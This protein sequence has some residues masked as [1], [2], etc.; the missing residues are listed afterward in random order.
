MFDGCLF[1]AKKYSAWIQLPKYEYRK[2]ENNSRT[3]SNLF[4]FAK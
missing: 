1:K 3:F 2:L 4:Q